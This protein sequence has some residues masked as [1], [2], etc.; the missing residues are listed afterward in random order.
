MSPNDPFG[1]APG[2][3]RSL[4]RPLALAAIAL[5]FAG[6]IGAGWLEFGDAPRRPGPVVAPDP[7]A[8]PDARSPVADPARAPA[9]AARVEDLSPFERA[10]YHRGAAG[11]ARLYRD[12][13]RVGAEL[14][15]LRLVRRFPG[16]TSLRIAAVRLAAE[17]GDAAAAATQFLAAAQAGLREIEPYAT[18]PLY[19]GM[20]NEAAYA[21]ALKLLESRRAEESAAAPEDDAA[22]DPPE[23]SP[24]PAHAPVPAPLVDG[25]AVIA[26]GNSEWSEIDGAVRAYI[27]MPPAPQGP[28]PVI[29]GASPAA[30]L[31]N[32]LIAAGRAAGNH[33][34]FYENRDD[35]HSPFDLARFPLI[36]PVEHAPEARV[37]G[38]ARS[39]PL[40]L[41]LTVA[42]KTAPPLF[43][44][45]STAITKGEGWR[46]IARQMVSSPEAAQELWREYASNQIYIYPEHRDH[47]PLYGD[48][49]PANTP[50]QI[51]TQG[52][53]WSDR[54][55][56][57]SVATILAAFRPETKAA[58]VRERLIAPTVQMI[59]R[60]CQAGIV[61]DADYLSPRAH[62]SVF[63]PETVEPE[64]MV[65]MA[66]ALLPEEIPPAPRLQ[67]LDQRR[68]AKGVS[69][70]GDGLSETLF[71][72]P[73]AIALLFRGV[74][75]RM[76]FTVT[77]AG[78]VDPN[79][80]PLEFRWALMRGDPERVTI[81][82]L[83][84]DGQAAEI[85]VDWQQDIPV[86]GD[87]ALN[88]QR[89]EVAVFVDNGAWI[90]APAFVSV[91]FPP[92]QHRIY[93][94]EGRLDMVDYDALSRQDVYAD[95]LLWPL[96][97]WRDVALHDRQ[98]RPLGW[99]RSADESFARFTRHGAQVTET[100][101]LGRPVRAVSM[102]YPVLN[103]GPYQRRV[104]QL[105]AGR[106]L[107]YDYAGPDDLQGV[108]RLAP[109]RAP[110]AAAPSSDGA[111]PA[112]PAPAD[113]TDAFSAD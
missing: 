7:G 20:R 54:A 109:P 60:R 87:P 56:M 45:S 77:A 41:A 93:G 63:P 81:R 11:V 113:A 31:L 46:S 43:G 3:R 94:P 29:G 62:P 24:P 19:A 82:P 61:T 30:A 72:T 38:F 16:V 50:Y 69:L 57:E 53:S 96:R 89:V 79:G 15:V 33:G 5:G 26:A 36:T 85:T 75:A 35:D 18:A 84:D 67:L 86:P 70:F 27:S 4:T 106:E 59:W 92:R 12:G 55:A 48:L 68:P 88:S 8:A 100:D 58:L 98:G 71:E 83:G 28:P 97:E 74:D 52:S 9:R 32:R 44:N 39:A 14:E 80:R 64:R 101:D 73:S 104:A 107:L 21:L 103:E 108:A 1:R 10:F 37:A 99:T 66:N 6:L 51:V 78:S 112:P 111:P 42:G 95:P 13:D 65:R 47:D 90:S 34:D 91:A 2:E 49:F 40:G 25:A 22:S 102:A 17:R 23:V 105:P 110:D 76:R